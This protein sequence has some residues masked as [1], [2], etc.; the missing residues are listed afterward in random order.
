MTQGQMNISPSNQFTTIINIQV[1]CNQCDSIY[2]GRSWVKIKVISFLR[3]G[4]KKVVM[5]ITLLIVRSNT[6]IG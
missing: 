1:I 6:T 3:T 2:A 4:V 5:M